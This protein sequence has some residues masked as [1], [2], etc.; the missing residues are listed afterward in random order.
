[1]FIERRTVLEFEIR[2][3]RNRKQVK[4]IV[5][6]FINDHNLRVEMSCSNDVSN[7]A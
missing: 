5:S 2:G 6:T 4:K 7:K 1:M 3:N